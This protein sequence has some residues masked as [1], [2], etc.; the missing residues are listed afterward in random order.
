MVIGGLA[1][2]MGNIVK[3]YIDCMPQCFWNREDEGI[4]DLR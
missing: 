3:M 2:N 4:G 1:T